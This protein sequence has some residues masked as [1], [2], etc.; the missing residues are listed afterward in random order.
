MAF[1]TSLADIILPSK[2]CT[3]FKCKVSNKYT[4]GDSARIIEPNV[5]TTITHFSQKKQKTGNLT[6]TMTQ[7]RDFAITGPM[8]SDNF[9]SGD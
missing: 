5:S 9:I 2:D 8:V 1:S 7:S 4:K 3:I 6:I